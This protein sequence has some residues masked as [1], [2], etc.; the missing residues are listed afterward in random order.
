MHTFPDRVERSWWQYGI[1]FAFQSGK[2][3]SIREVQK[4]RE[5][6]IAS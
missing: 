2:I 1:Y 3:I 5:E 4:I 6:K